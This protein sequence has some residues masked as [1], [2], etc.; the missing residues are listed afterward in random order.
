MSESK[1]RHETT[2]NLLSRPIA[3]LNGVVKPSSSIDTSQS[4]YAACRSAE[5]YAF[6]HSVCENAGDVVPIGP[7]G[8]DN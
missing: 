7:M 6:T 8:E 4:R 2:H 1:S 5:G 3:I